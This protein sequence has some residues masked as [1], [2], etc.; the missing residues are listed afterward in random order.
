MICCCVPAFLAVDADGLAFLCLYEVAA[1][2]R[3]ASVELVAE[4]EGL[5]GRG[6]AR[7]G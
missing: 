1:H 4:V 6:A 2:G 7:V 5:G 3:V